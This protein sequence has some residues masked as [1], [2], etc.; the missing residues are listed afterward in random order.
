[1]DI[2]HI[3]V[4]GLGYVGL[5]LAVALARR[6]QVTGL[7]VDPRRIAELEQNHDRTGEIDG[8]LLAASSLAL[9]SDAGACAGADIYIVT[10]PT[11]VDADN[12]PDLGA[13]RGAT[14]TVGRLLDAGR[15]P[16]IV[17]ESTVYP[18][19]T[20]EV[21]GPLLERVSGLRCGEDFFLG[22]SP[23]RINPGDREHTVDRIIKVVAGQNEAVTETL[24]EVYGAVTSAGVF[25]AA[26]IK[27]AEA[28]KVIENAQRDINIAFMNEI[29]QIF[30]KLDLSIWDVLEAA[31]TKWNFLRFQPGLVGGHCIGVDPYYLSYR[32]QQLGHDPD[33]ILAGRSTNDGMGAWVADAL[34]ERC[35][36]RAGS[37][38][39]L[40]LTFKEDVP[41][42]R[43]SRVIDVIRR[44]RELGHEVIVHDPRADPA[45]ARH[46]YGIDLD[47]AA[48]DRTYDLVFAAVPH[49][50]YRAMSAEQ[51]LALAAPGACIGDLKGIWRDRDLGPDVSRWTL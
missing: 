32:A 4:V 12:R 3:V 27:A 34:H 20:E 43:N 30:A 21:C 25:R 50:E 18:G 6:F 37:V 17:Y 48:L 7:D 47:A 33:V 1:M 2:R 5:P 36:G 13:V 49:A 39:V 14:E 35:G 16:I 24:A 11:P 51:V 31:G 8:E 29:T 46:E 26:S 19:V 40:G 44:L 15:R 23:E 9:T 41:D 45:E 22:Y 42:L 38:L 10:V 28:A